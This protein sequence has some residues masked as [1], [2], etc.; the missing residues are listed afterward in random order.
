[1]I[2]KPGTPD[3]QRTRFDGGVWRYHPVRD[4]W[5]PYADGTTNPW[6]IDWND[7]GHAFVCNCVNPHLFQVIQGAHY[8]PWR[9]R[10]SGQYAYQRIDTIADHLHFVGLGNVRNGLGSDAEDA[11]GG[12]HAHCGTMI[13]LGDSFPAAYRNQLFTNNIH[14][15]RINNDLLRRKGSG[16]VASHGPDLMRSQDPWFM[17]VTLAYGP[18]GEVYVSDWSDTGECH[19]IRNTRKHTGRIYRITYMDTDTDPVEDVAKMTNQQ[20][21]QLQKHD[22]DWWVRHARRV[23]LERAQTEDIQSLHA[24]LW[25]Q[26][27]QAKT[28]PKKLRSLW[29]LRVTDGVSADELVKLLSEDDEHLHAWAIQFLCEDRKPPRHALERMLELAAKGDSGLVRLALASALQRLS[30]DDRWPLAEA[31]AKRRDDVYDQNLPLMIWYGI[32][33]LIQDDLDRYVELTISS[34]IPQIRIN[35]SRRIASSPMSDEGLELLCQAL[36]APDTSRRE[37]LLTGILQGLEGRRKVTM[38]SSWPKA[39]SKLDTS[40]DPETR[41]KAAQ[42]ALIFHDEDAKRSMV[43]LA[44]NPNADS[45]SRTRYQCFGGGKN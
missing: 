44:D 32:E 43:L 16:Y 35:M 13:Y 41:E 2:G 33:P 25:A 11:A 17:G 20:L 38:P 10:K 27:N 36:A 28:T 6:G 26:M 18:G 34:A 31:L 4:V 3:E 19:S 1:M 14:G 39:H 45:A 9:G 42:L 30:P 15:R 24:D 8:E 40:V 22:N 12:G 37:D 29:A 23:L 21:L 5:E 7:Y